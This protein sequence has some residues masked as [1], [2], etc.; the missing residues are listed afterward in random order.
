[1]RHERDDVWKEEFMCCRTEAGARVGLERGY[2]RRDEPLLLLLLKAVVYDGAVVIVGNGSLCSRTV[3]RAKEEFLSLRDR[4]CCGN[5]CR[6]G[7]R[8]CCR[9]AAVIV[10]SHCL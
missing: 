10:G 1:V 5:C 2:R 9:E 4:C 6:C 3:V 7:N 8:C